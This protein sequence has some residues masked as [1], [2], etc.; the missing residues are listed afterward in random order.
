M[1]NKSESI[2][3]EPE[4]PKS[5][6]TPATDFDIAPEK[7]EEIS[8]K[9]GNS[10]TGIRNFD[11]GKDIF[12]VERVLPKKAPKNTTITVAKK[13]TLTEY[14]DRKILG[15]NI[16]GVRKTSNKRQYSKIFPKSNLE[17]I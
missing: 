4:V 3:N 12:P 17:C 13:T 14:K 5:K 8:A 2:K 11:L 7:K 1:K 10:A 15:K 9:S 6:T 16:T